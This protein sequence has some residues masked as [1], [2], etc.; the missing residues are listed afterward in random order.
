M[1]LIRV[2]RPAL[3]TMLCLCA[4]TAE[5]QEAT[6][7]SSDGVVYDSQRNANG[8]VLTV[9]SEIPEGVVAPFTIYLGT[10]CDAEAPGFGAGT[11]G[12]ANGGFVAELEKIRVGF[13]RQELQDNDALVCGF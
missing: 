7:Q 2:W 6:F 10:S 11:W 1:S 12:W 8:W 4:V 13:P 3:A 9:A 5:A